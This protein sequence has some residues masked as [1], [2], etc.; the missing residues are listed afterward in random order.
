MHI[1]IYIYI[2]IYIYIYYI[3]VCFNAWEEW[4]VKEVVVLKGA[5]SFF[6]NAAT[7][8]IKDTPIQPKTT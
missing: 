4:C 1:Y 8:A 3:W 6:D 7:E 2:I 5:F